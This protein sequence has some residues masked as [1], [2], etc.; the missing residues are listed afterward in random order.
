MFRDRN[1]VFMW[2]SST[3]LSIILFESEDEEEEERNDR[4]VERK[5]SS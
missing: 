1:D 2:P 5:D 3:V 4:V